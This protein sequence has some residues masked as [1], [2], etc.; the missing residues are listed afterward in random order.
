MSGQR[1]TVAAAVA[2][3]TL[4]GVV[5]VAGSALAQDTTLRVAMGSP[6]EAGIRVWQDIEAQFEAAHPGVDVE[7]EY[8]GDDIYQTIG[9]PTLLSGPNA[10]DVYFDWTGSRMAQRDADGYAADLTDV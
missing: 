6:G 3:A 5:G 10:P 8:Q 4:L 7:I 9:L 1:R 2:A